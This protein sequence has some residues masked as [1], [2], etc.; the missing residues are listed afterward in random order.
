VQ[1]P[2]IDSL[3]DADLERLNESLGWAAFVEDSRGRRF[4]R[5]SR[6]DTPQKIPDGRIRLLEARFDLKQMKVLELGC[7]EGIHTVALAERAA[8]VVAV[9]AR[10][11]NVLKTMVRCGRSISGQRSVSGASKILLRRILIA[12]VICYFTS[13]CS[14]I[15]PTRSGTFRRC[16]L[17]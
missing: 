13:A 11:E 12:I 17:W 5:S 15:W 8:G 16:V 3:S 2:R 7:F 4:G 14:T 1:I 10:I 9:D 6:R